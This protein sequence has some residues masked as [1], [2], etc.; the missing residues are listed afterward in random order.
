MFYIKLLHSNHWTAVWG[1]LD[2]YY[3]CTD[4]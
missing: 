3:L 1:S 2:V 4:Q